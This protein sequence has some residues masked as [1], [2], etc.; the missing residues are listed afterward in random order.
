MLSGSI[1][2][3]PL[4][5]MVASAVSAL[6]LSIVLDVSALPFVAYSR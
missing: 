6:T 4:V 3:T 2:P 1:L 5:A